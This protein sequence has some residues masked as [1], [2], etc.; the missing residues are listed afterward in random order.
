MY[1]P[2]YKSAFAAAKQNRE[3][4][5]R[6]F[7]KKDA[8]AN[9]REYSL[10]GHIWGDALVL[11]LIEGIPDQNLPA[12][13]TILIAKGVDLECRNTC[14]LYTSPSPRDS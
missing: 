5:A 3:A 7:D 13:L 12:L 1:N 6:E 10:G 4:F 8:D 11:K 14:L 9:V 2:F